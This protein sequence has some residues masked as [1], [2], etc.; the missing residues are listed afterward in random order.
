MQSTTYSAC[1]QSL[2]AL[3]LALKRTHG[4]HAAKATAHCSLLTLYPPATWI[5][6]PLS[7]HYLMLGAVGL[8]E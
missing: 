2:A 8:K 3:A 6:Q 1:S 4:I 7:G 5:R